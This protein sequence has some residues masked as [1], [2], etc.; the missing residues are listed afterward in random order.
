MRR[1]LARRG[2]ILGLCALLVSL[3]SP[4]APTL[5]QVLEPSS[6]WSVPLSRPLRAM[7]VTDMDGDQQGEILTVCA[8]G[9]ISLL[10]ADGSPVWQLDRGLE[11]TAAVLANV[12]GNAQPEL[13]LGD[14]TGVTALRA[15][16]SSVWVRRTLFPVETLDVLDRNADG[17][18]EVIV[19]TRSQNVYE[20]S[21]TGAVLWHYTAPRA[22]EDRAVGV[23]IAD[24]DADG[25][26]EVAVAFRR[27]TD[28]PML[29][30]SRLLLLDEAGEEVWWK[31][32]RVA[33][34][35]L[36]ALQPDEKRAPFLVAGTTGGACL[37]LDGENTLRWYLDVGAPV[38]RLLERD[39]DDDGLVELVVMTNKSLC[40]YDYPDKLLWERS[41]VGDVVEA[42]W[43]EGGSGE[44]CVALLSSSDAQ[45]STVDILNARDEGTVLES[46]IWPIAAEAVRLADVNADGFG[47][48]VTFSGDAVQLW[49]RAQGVAH[50]QL[51]LRYK[52]PGEVTA[53]GAA[54]VTEDGRF[55]VL[56]GSRDRSLYVLNHDGWL[57]WRYNAD[58]GIRSIITGDADGDGQ[59]EIMVSHNPTEWQDQAQRSGLLVLEGDGRILHHY[60]AGNWIWCNA[61]GDL[62][63]DQQ[64][65]MVAGLGYDRIVAMG[66]ARFLWSY[67]TGGSVMTLQVADLDLD[68]KA[69]VLAG[70]EDD[71]AYV[72]SGDGTLRW[73]YNAGSDVRAVASTDLD[74]DGWGEIII[75]SEAGTVFAFRMDRTLLWRYELRD[76]PLALYVG[77]LTAGGRSNIYV[78]ASSGLYL[79]NVNGSLVW[80]Y[81]IPGG[82]IFAGEGDVDGDDRAELVAGTSD[83]SVYVVS[84]D[85]NL[86][87]QH[88]FD[89]PVSALH[90]GD[91]DGDGTEE[92]LVGTRDGYFRMFKHMPNR[93]PLVANAK[94]ARARA[95]YVYTVSAHDPEGDE[96][97]A[98]LEIYDPFR[99]AW[100][101]AGTQT[102]S[103][104]GTIYWFVDPFPLLSS[105]RTSAYRIHY[106]D[107]LN[108]GTIGPI[109]GPVVPGPPWYL[110]IAAVVA[111]GTGVW[112]W[113][114]WQR[115]TRKRS[116]E[117]YRRWARNPVEMLRQIHRLVSGRGDPSEI[118]IRLAKMARSD[119]NEAVA[120]L[121]E[122]YLLLLTR[123]AAG[124]RILGS[125]VDEQ[126]A[127]DGHEPPWKRPLARF[128]ELLADL[129]EANSVPRVAALRPR[130]RQMLRSLRG[131]GSDDAA[132]PVPLLGRIEALVEISRAASLLHD[133]ERAQHVE[134]K[135]DYL[136]R[137]S[138]ALERLETFKGDPEKR[139]IAAIATNWQQ[140]IATLRDDWLGSALLRCR[141][142]T[143]RIIG[144][145]E[146]VLVVEVRNT[147]RSPAQN[148]TI[149]LS[150]DG[151]YE[152]LGQPAVLGSIMPGQVRETEFHL[153][154]GG[155]GRF[156]AEFTLRYDD[157]QAAGRTQ[158]FADIIEVLT[159]SEFQPIPNPYVPGRPLGPASPLFYGRE[160]VFDFISQNAQGMRQRNILILIGQRRTGKTSVLLQLPLRLGD[161]Y[162]PVYL[163]GQSLGLT[164]GLPAL[165]YDVATTI[166]DTLRDRGIEVRVPSLE[167]LQSRTARVFEQ[168]F[169]RD[170]RAA[171]GDRTILL[172]LDE[173]EELEMRVRTDKLEPTVFP[174]LRHLMQ[175]SERLAFVFV[176]THR[177]EEMTTD[178]WSVLFNIALYRHITY[179]DEY[180]AHR[181]ITEPVA[182]YN[183]VYD[184]L[185]LNKMLQVTAGHPY[186]LQLLCYSLVNAH[187][188]NQRSY[189]TVDDV[190]EA[191]E[192]ILTLGG[193]HFAFLWETSTRQER[194]VL[195]ILTRLL[196]RMGQAA[197]P[198][199]GVTASDVALQ[200]GE[201]GITIDARDLSATL[202]NLAAREILAVVPDDV[203]RYVFKIGLVALWIERHKSLTRVIEELA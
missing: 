197:W 144:A 33:V 43:E 200:L 86:K 90:V 69:E 160:D 118:L 172:I 2:C 140:V 99:R 77:E 170:V 121:A 4:L 180:S 106:N 190:D 162:I 124:L 87:E 122:G 20:L 84:D 113:I 163:D 59:A 131:L 95:G 183:M 45:G 76:M 191:L 137:A 103:E 15:D 165:L 179:L 17:L 130:L 168:E 176:G 134:D 100:R 133:G 5:A 58:G 119:A 198:E 192:D 142:Q 92:I 147:G 40:A 189:V 167:E 129:Y 47:E 14:V 193:A 28:Q 37:M 136:A 174:Y 150:G 149:E 21:S 74:L 112:G 9:Y 151:D 18:A 10:E 110:Y 70:S 48:L 101:S 182:A 181:L 88:R 156:R 46:Y 102:A 91:V 65:E 50:T 128:Y 139:I 57:S 161:Q 83:G 35:C 19:V 175:H 79:L 125:T 71:R 75:A 154:P 8:D 27:S 23:A 138:A 12:D 55:E 98:T 120:N 30:R 109:S 141:L 61:A 126:I 157:P 80:E 117:L 49:P 199:R 62:D 60:E 26:D 105:G 73:F 132:F 93:P 31:E 89:Q 185:A 41:V 1:R 66:D 166:G 145:R 32:H 203:E 11:T 64:E 22:T 81:N 42:V 94:V 67:H 16:G 53:L 123:P 196:P 52:V 143:K 85:G 178:Y 201:H 135:L 107:G 177:L 152:V 188:R 158:N 38:S 184:D 39:L 146:A 173:F 78:A 169:L 44:D 7:F 155:E 96:V 3:L 24:Y 25:R 51:A 186:F 115:S 127:P 202:R 195:L 148:T 108:M 36:L 187:N 104:G 13:I 116:S 82:V 63:G 6:Q 164:P 68:G 114:G 72:L 34:T 194:A 171:T 153:T 56:I 97:Q 29:V 54:N 111:A 159:P